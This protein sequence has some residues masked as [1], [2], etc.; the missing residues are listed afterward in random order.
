MTTPVCRSGYTQFLLF[1]SSHL[2]MSCSLTTFLGFLFWFPRLTELK[3]SSDLAHLWESIT[4]SYFWWS[5]SGR[6]TSVYFFHTDL[7]AFSLPFHLTVKFGCS[8]AHISSS[9][10]QQLIAHVRKYYLSTLPWGSEPP[11]CKRPRELRVVSLSCL[12]KNLVWKLIFSRYIMV[13]IST[14]WKSSL[15]SNTDH[16]LPSLSFPRGSCYHQFF[17]LRSRNTQDLAYPL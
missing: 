13:L 12:P 6:G 4:I 2:I 14:L 11:T 15:S 3:S 1:C 16:P 10:T 8:G 7:G 9:H 17:V 5:Y